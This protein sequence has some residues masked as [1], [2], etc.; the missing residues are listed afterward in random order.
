M[1]TNE[2]ILGILAA[3]DNLSGRQRRFLLALET[4]PRRADGWQVA[5]TQ[6]LAKAAGVSLNTAIR[7]RD[8][9]A[10]AGLIG[11]QRGNGRGNFSAYEAHLKMIITSD[12]HRPSEALK[13][14]ITSDGYLSGAAQSGKGTQTASRKVPKPPNKGTQR[15]ALTSTDSSA[16]LKESSLKDPAPPARAREAAAI[17]RA[18]FPDLTD[19]ETRQIVK[20]I[21]SEHQ[22]RDLRA[23]VKALAAS[24]DLARYVPCDT[25]A[26]GPHSEACRHG[27]G[28]ACRMDWCQCRC[29]GR[30]P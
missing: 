11:Y 8:E 16:S 29:H 28:A 9:L 4:F 10:E 13:V 19:D 6:A 25:A 30:R 1:A 3:W 24:G 27:D 7:A 2:V 23:Y 22:P 26:P 17:V 14:V 18:A 20:T 21:I 12:G 5:G 15:N